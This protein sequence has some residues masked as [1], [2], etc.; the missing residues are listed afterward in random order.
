MKNKCPH[1]GSD[2]TGAVIP[3]DIREYYGN[4]THFSRTIAIYD[5]VKDRTIEYKCPDCGKRWPQ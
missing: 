2:Q 1:C 3:A 4:E 5:E